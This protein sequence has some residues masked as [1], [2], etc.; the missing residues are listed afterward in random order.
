LT[1]C[2]LGEWHANGTTARSGGRAD[3]QLPSLGYEHYDA[4]LP[5]LRRPGAS[6]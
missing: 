1:A 5:R 2:C 6:R 4:H 3:E